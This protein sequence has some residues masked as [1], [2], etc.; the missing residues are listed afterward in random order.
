MA[1][2][3]AQVV[4]PMFTNTPEDVVTNTFYFEENV[5]LGLAAVAA[6][7]TPR[8]ATF[9]NSVY[10]VSSSMGSYMS[11]ASTTIRWYD[12]SQPEPRVPLITNPTMSI[13][14]AVTSVPTEA[15]AVLSFQADRQPGV[16]QSRRRGR[17][18]LGGLGPG[19]IFAGSASAFPSIVSNFR[20]VATAAANTLR[21]AV[22]SDGLRWVVWSP[23]AQQSATITNGW[24]DNAIDTQ[25]RRSVVRTGRTVFP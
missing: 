13:T 22:V 9:Y 6:A 23:T 19:S 20:T 17:I 21:T 1:L 4:I 15:S 24:M 11:P 25:R 12:M 10:G 5:P 7:L 16:P 2:F 14:T 3:R 8:L 18:Y